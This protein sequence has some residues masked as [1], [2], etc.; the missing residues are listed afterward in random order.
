MTLVIWKDFWN[1]NLD[2][3]CLLETEVFTSPHHLTSPHIHSST[4]TAG[5]HEWAYVEM[6]TMAQVSYM[7][8]RNW[9]LMYSTTEQHF[10][11]MQRMP[12]TYG[13]KAAHH[14]IFYWS[15]SVVGISP[16]RMRYR[17]WNETL[18]L[19]SVIPSFFSLTY[20][21][22]EIPLIFLSDTDIKRSS[23]RYNIE[24]VYFFQFFITSKQWRLSDVEFI[25]VKIDSNNK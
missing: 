18:T 15:L 19:Q 8:K 6:L 10:L 17:I 5:A 14:N 23:I 21:G 4:W 9:L 25:A 2:L 16:P 7:L 22:S 13:H 11:P 24:H 12:H 1:L 3:Y 20:L